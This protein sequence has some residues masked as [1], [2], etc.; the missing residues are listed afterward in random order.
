M[1]TVSTPSSARVLLVDDNADMRD[2]VR[3]LLSERWQVETAANG[4]I[5][6]DLIQRKLP[7][8][9]LTDVMMPE[10]DGFQLLNALRSDPV[11]KSIPI[12][13]LSARAGEEATVVGLEA[14]ADDY[15][16]KPFSA[17]ELMARVETQLQMSRL[18]QERSANRLKD[19]FLATLTHEL[20][21]PLAAILTWARLLQTQPFD[22]PMMLRALDAIERNAN[23]QAKL[24]EDL[25][26]MSSILAG[27]RG[28]NPQ[29]VDLVA[30]ID[31]VLNRLYPTAE[32]KAIAL[33]YSIDD[34]GLDF[35][36]PANG[37]CHATT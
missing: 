29:P 11:T 15:L 10:V 32:K 28:L 2:Y 19:E 13:L 27:K 5:A 6:L 4:A 37:K 14:G 7:D 25:L 36:S 22:R 35:D 34:S 33:T 30:I 18:R 3:R 26:D 21:A 9:V 1:K 24:I 8:L 16:I 12:I 20:N 23:N 17:R 31:D